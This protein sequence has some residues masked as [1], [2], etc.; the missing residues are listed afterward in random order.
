[1]ASADSS[2]K[3]SAERMSLNAVGRPTHFM[4]ATDEDK[5]N[6]WR[7]RSQ[8][9]EAGAHCIEVP[10]RVP[11]KPIAKYP[12][13]LKAK[14]HVKYVESYLSDKIGVAPSAY[15]KRLAKNSWPI[16]LQD[17]E[18][19]ATFKA[20]GNQ[21]DTLFMTP[22]ENATTMPQKQLIKGDDILGVNLVC[23]P[24]LPRRRQSG[25]AKSGHEGEEEDHP[26]MGRRLTF[27]EFK[28]KFVFPF[29]LRA[30][31]EAT[32]DDR[33]AALQEKYNA[34]KE[35]NLK[36]YGKPPSRSMVD[37]Y[38]VAA[39][40]R[41][42]N[43]GQSLRR[44]ASAASWGAKG[45]IPND[46]D[47]SNLSRGGIPWNPFIDEDLAVIAEGKKPLE[48]KLKQ[49][50]YLQ[51]KLVGIMPIH[52]LRDRIGPR[53]LQ[54]LVEEMRAMSTTRLIARLV[55]FLCHKLMGPWP[56]TAAA[57]SP[58]PGSPRSAVGGDGSPRSVDEGVGSLRL[59]YA[60][61]V[62]DPE[63]ESTMFVKIYE[64]YADL[65]SRLRRRRSYT[66]FHL[67]VI[68]M[69]LRAA[70]EELFR[71]M[72]PSYTRTNTGK[73]LLRD[74]DAAVCAMFDPDAWHSKISFLEGS[75]DSLSI[76]R[77][78]RNQGGRK[79]AGLG[80]DV[81]STSPVIRNL[82]SGDMGSAFT[83]RQTSVT[84]KTS[85]PHEAEDG[86]RLLPLRVREQ[87]FRAA[88]GRASDRA[89]KN[90]VVFTRK[91]GRRLNSSK[92]RREEHGGGGGRVDDGALGSCLQDSWLF[93]PEEREVDPLD[94]TQEGDGLAAGGE[95]AGGAG[96]G[97]A[98]TSSWDK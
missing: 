95:T 37:A 1:M 51:E 58:P 28:E 44:E 94:K 34:D 73:Q 87:L 91:D 54:L 3:P 85:T 20:R 80:A 48:I 12:T 78:P 38:E 98:Y 90:G 96:S 76:L 83:K 55:H 71:D 18:V 69:M 68:M 67:P 60:G 22:S 64:T 32:S 36:I 53:E 35:K 74:V 31:P 33:M 79:G 45:T 66:L 4:A 56:T 72:Y 70:C 81:Y 62:R 84:A 39:G 47:V 9:G 24:R 19:T 82:F 97:P 26:S 14:L 8:A 50:K 75:R 5:A 42:G 86:P 63:W 2:S 77:D 61:P 49:V 6:N 65:Y 88:L 93:T 57:A 7:K 17:T 25:G 21:G 13:E 92:E 89:S 15:N 59:P 29:S 10:L 23:K 46:F 30:Q 16:R 52:D 40:R 41:A 11:E 27:E 43:S